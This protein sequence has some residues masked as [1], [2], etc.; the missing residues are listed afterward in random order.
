MKARLLTAVVTGL[1]AGAVGV[2]IAFWIKSEYI[3]ALAL[4]TAT[5]GFFFG[6]LF[7]FQ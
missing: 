4:I 5:I 2:G 7:K 6:L 1:I 3:V